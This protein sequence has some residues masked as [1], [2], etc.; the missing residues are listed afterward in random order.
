MAS[1]ERREH[2]RLIFTVGRLFA[3]GIIIPIDASVYGEAVTFVERFKLSPQDALIYAA[4]L[5]HIRSGDRPGP[6]IFINKNWKD[7]EQPDILAEL[8]ALHCE[9]LRS[10]VEAESWLDRQPHTP[11][12]GT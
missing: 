7:F 3:I 9:F 1:I 11:G 2:E 12:I 4:V 10:F 6:H 8:A 5:V